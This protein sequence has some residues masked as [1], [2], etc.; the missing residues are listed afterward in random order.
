MAT[1]Q[2]LSKPGIHVATLIM[3]VIE[4][5]RANYIVDGHL[6][7]QSQ[8]I[9]V[10]LRR[11][12]KSIKDIGWPVKFYGEI[13]ERIDDLVFDDNLRLSALL[14]ISEEA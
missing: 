2:S 12:T 7:I 4:M 5:L 8:Q 13:L 3:E 14:E 10:L 6:R 11:H 1:E 9:I